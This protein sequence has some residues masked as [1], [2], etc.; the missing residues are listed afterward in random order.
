MPPSRLFSIHK[1]KVEEV[2]VKIFIIFHY[3]Q[4]WLL[5][6]T[7][8][9]ILVAASC[10]QLNTIKHSADP[11]FPFPIAYFEALISRHQV[12]INSWI[13]KL[14]ILCTARRAK[15]WHIEQH[16]LKRSVCEEPSDIEAAKCL[17]QK[18]KNEPKKRGL[19]LRQN[20]MRISLRTVMRAMSLTGGDW[21]QAA[22][23]FNQTAHP[24][25]HQPPPVDRRRHF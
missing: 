25:T 18:K 9:L 13:E 3:F 23:Q 22:P 8:N 5:E 12:L 1:K 2:N 14:F 7:L 11:L 4:G 19:R 21:R 24:P 10:R 16:F 6:H 20:C 15:V 17:P